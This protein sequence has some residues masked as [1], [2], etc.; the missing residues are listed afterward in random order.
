MRLK[1]SQW[2]FILG[3]VLLGCSQPAPPAEEPPAQEPAGRHRG[4]WMLKAEVAESC[5]C[6]VS[7]PCMFGS[8]AT[9]EYCR[10]SRLVRIE[11]GRYG[12]VRLDG[13][14]VVATFS[15]G[16]W[17]RYYVDE[18]ASQEQAEAA[19]KLI[20]AAFPSFA[21]WGVE[22]SQKAAV[23][24]EQTDSVLYFAVPESEVKMEVMAG[25]NGQPVRI[26]NL[27]N[28]FP[29]LIQYRSIHN[30]HAS[31]DHEFDYTGTNGFLAKFTSTDGE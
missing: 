11:E 12:H 5:S 3:F 31:S 14:N 21:R 8:P 7:C 20:S 10:G 16:E 22:S 6:N 2:I 30:R 13:L 28:F 24:V 1:W 19:G 15:M 26:E 18:K 25:G 27:P 9:H 17:V 29:S 23:H 4:Q